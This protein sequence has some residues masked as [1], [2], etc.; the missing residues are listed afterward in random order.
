MCMNAAPMGALLLLQRYSYHI[1]G[2]TGLKIEK[3]NSME[4]TLKNYYGKR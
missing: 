4:R 3:A 1:I 2:H